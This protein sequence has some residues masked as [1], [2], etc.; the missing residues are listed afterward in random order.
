MLLAQI[1]DF[2]IRPEGRLAYGRVDTAAFLARTVARLAELE[3]RP[4]VVLATGDLVDAGDPDEYAHL[5]RLLAPLALP[6][7]VLPG[8]HDSRAGLSEAFRDHAYLPRDGEFL[9]Y[10]VED[11]PLRLIG[12]DTTV[13]GEPGGRLCDRRLAWLE[14]RLAE[15]PERPT[16]LMMHHPPMTTGIDHMDA[17]GLESPE[18]LAEILRRHDQVERIICG[19]VHRS[20]QAS[21]AGKPASVAPSTAHQV[22]LDLSADGAARYTL[23]PAGFHLHLWHPGSAIVTHSAYV[24]GFPGPFAFHD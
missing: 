10:V 15:A 22:M 8:N 9:H 2:H 13:P 18:R 23:E 14:A 5:R 17:M 11:W 21:F 3:P 20:I 24:D 4:D 6:L 16:L 19:H 1:T 7:Y 12:L